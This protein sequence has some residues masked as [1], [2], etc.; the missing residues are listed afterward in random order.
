MHPTPGTR[1]IVAVAAAVVGGA[2]AAG[3]IAWLGWAWYQSRLPATYSVMDYA[4]PDGGGAP[5]GD[6]SMHHAHGGRS[7]VDLVGPRG[8]PARRFVL[9]AHDGPV[10]LAS[11]REVQA[12]SFNGSVPGPELRMRVGELV[13]VKLVNRNVKNGVTVHWHGIDVPNGEDGVAG[14]TQ[15]AVPPGGSH[16]YRFR[17]SQVGT[18]WYH[19]HQASSS[20]VRRGLYGAVVIEPAVPPAGVTDVVVAVHTLEGT[21]LVNSVDGVEQRAVAPG[22]P[23]RLR[24]INTDSAPQSYDLGGTPFRVVAIDGTDLVGPTPLRN[25]TLVLAAGGRYDLAFTMPATP[26]MLA[27]EDTLAGLVLSASGK[28][29]PPR[30][31]SGPE[32]DPAVYG[33]PAPTPFGASSHFDRVFTLDVGRK[34]GFFNGQPGHAVDD[35]R[36]HLPARADVHGREGRSRARLD[37]EHDGR[38]APDASPR[39][40]HARAQPEREAVT[41]SPWWSDTLNVEPGDAYDVAFRADNPGIWM[42]H[43]HNLSHAAAGLT[44][45][46]AYMGVTT[47]FETGEQRPQ[48]PGMRREGRQPAVS[49]HTPSIRPLPARSQAPVPAPCHRATCR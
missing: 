13:E 37:Q 48:P 27:V 4:I 34:P 8:V 31:S 44:M 3:A 1:R 19:T 15:D 32:F 29:D 9:T 41:G 30:P 20:D 10:R 26:V 17:A 47:P 28:A 39:S 49:P 36:W 25:T 7:V 24:L 43:C 40:P 6:T 23:V 45:H 46:V 42:D 14:V 22:T 11:G 33:R 5:V 38:R 35:Q 16:V 12:L 2:L 18:F 21:P